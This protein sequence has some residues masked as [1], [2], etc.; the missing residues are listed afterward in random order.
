MNSLRLRHFVQQMTLTVAR[1]GGSSEAAL[2]DRG[3]ALMLDLITH[4]DWLP[5]AF[6]KPDPDK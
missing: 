3:Q 2:L 6:A 5:D 1:E 4:D